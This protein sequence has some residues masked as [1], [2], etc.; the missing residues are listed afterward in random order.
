MERLELPKLK[1]AKVEAKVNAI[2]PIKVIVEEN[3]RVRAD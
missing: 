2:T 1:L 3:R